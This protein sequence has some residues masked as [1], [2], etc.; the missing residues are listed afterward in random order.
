M[1]TKWAEG[2]TF[3]D[4]PKYLVLR[5]AIARAVE[6][7]HLAVGAKLPPVRELAYRLSITPGTVAR[8]YS[9]LTD[10]GVLRGEVGRGTFVDQIAGPVFSDPG[11]ETRGVTYYD[12]VPHGTSHDGGAVSM[13][14]PGIPSLGQAEYLRALLGRISLDPPSGLMHYPTRESFKPVRQAAKHWLRH[15]GLG[16]LDEIDIVLSH[17]G[18]NAIMLVMQAVL[19]GKRPT[20]LVEELCYR[21]FRR[22]AQLLRADVVPVAMDQYGIMPKSLEAAAGAEAQL[23][24]TTANLHNPT[25]TFTPETR[26]REIAEVARRCNFHILEDDWYQVPSLGVPSYRQIAPE[27]S[28]YVSSIS[29]LVT[30]SLRIGFAVSPP[31]G[32]AHLRRA[33]EDGFFGLATILADVGTTLLTDPL[34]E[35]MVE[36][37][38]AAYRERLRILL[39]H[40]GGYDV[41]WQEDT[42]IVWLHLPEHWRTAAFCA[43][44]EAEGVRVRTSEDFAPRDART[45]HAVRISLNASVTME[46]FEQAALKLRNLLESPPERVAV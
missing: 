18:Q 5:D 2:L 24:C 13:M 31:G 27:R 42:P 46:A 11:A 23:L 1:D 20:V 25:C 38:R 16:A 35:D 4:G 32:G 21:G 34:V 30:P 9:I 45:P 14:S 44:A 37:V 36:R 3:R 15:S 28:W 43:A 33:A 6:Q 12:P 22:G 26:R 7:G 29:K 10:Q 17:G 39:N 40:L 41:K 8:A 19:R